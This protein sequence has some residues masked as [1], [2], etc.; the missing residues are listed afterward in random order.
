MTDRIEL[1]NIRAWGKHG[2][3]PSER[4]SE[5]PL[6]INLVLEIDLSSAQV[7]DALSDT[8]DYAV[9][10]GQVLQIVGNTSFSLLEKLAAE[11]L[12]AIFAHTLVKAAQISIAKPGVFDGATPIV[13][14]DRVNTKA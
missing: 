3:T 7:S 10:Y 14:I 9:I 5:Q 12:S 4:E 13:T 8:V 2:C 6:D 1:H 11:I